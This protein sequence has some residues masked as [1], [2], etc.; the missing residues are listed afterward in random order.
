MALVHNL[1]GWDALGGLVLTKNSESG[2]Y[3]GQMEIQVGM[4]LEYKYVL[5][6]SWIMLK[7]KRWR[8]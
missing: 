8:N 1:I 7:C 4:T 5:N 2:K 3:E 6:K